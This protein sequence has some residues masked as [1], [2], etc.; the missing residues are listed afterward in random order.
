MENEQPQLLCHVYVLKAPPDYNWRLPTSVL[1]IKEY[2]IQHNVGE[3]NGGWYILYIEK[4][5]M[6]VVEVDPS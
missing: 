4:T 2:R 3:V 1:G 5:I 6:Y